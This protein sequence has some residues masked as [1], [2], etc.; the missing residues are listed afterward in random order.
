MGIDGDFGQHHAQH[1]PARDIAEHRHIVAQA[2]PGSRLGYRLEHFWLGERGLAPRRLSDIL[3][4]RGIT[5]IILASH[6]LA[7]EAPLDFDWP[8]FSAVKIDFFPREPAIHHVTNDQRAILQLAVRR[9]LA[10]GRRRVGL[11]MPTWWDEIV[12]LAWSAGFLAE[13]Q[14]LPVAARIPMLTF[15]DPERQKLVPRSRL[16]AWLRRY[17]PDVIVSYAPFVRP[18]LTALGVEVP[19]DVAYVDTFL[20]EIDGQTAGVRQNCHRVGELAVEILAGQLHQN[21]L[22]LPAIPTATLVEGTWFD[23]ATLPAKP[24][25]ATAALGVG[26]QER[27]G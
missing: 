11:V 4:A 23:G 14:Q 12:D 19:R 1:G 10:A 24:L 13:Q 7:A 22:G 9:A 15:S 27:D 18:Q 17:R 3:V 25:R 21:A 5:G 16:A 6:Q 20:T 2:R 8:R 26:R